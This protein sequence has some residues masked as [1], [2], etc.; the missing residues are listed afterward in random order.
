MQMNNPPIPAAI[1]KRL[2][3]VGEF[4]YNFNEMDE[5]ADPMGL[6]NHYAP[7]VLTRFNLNWHLPTDHL[8][9]NAYRDVLTIPAGQIPIYTVPQINNSFPAGNADNIDPLVPASLLPILIPAQDVGVDFR[10][11]DIVSERNS[12]KKIGRNAEEYIIGVTRRGKT[13]FL[14]R[15]DDRQRNQNDQQM[16]R[17]DPGHLFQQ[18]CTPGYNL[19]AEYKHL[20]AGRIGTFQT[21]ITAEID[22]VSPDDGSFL[23][24]KSPLYDTSN[25]HL[26]DKWLQMFLGRF[27]CFKSREQA[28]PL[29]FLGGVERLIVGRRSNDQ[30][31]Q[32]LSIEEKQATNMIDDEIETNILRHLNQVLLFLR[33][34]VEEDRSYLLSRHRRNGAPQDM[35]VFLYEVVDPDD[36]NRLQFVPPWMLNQLQVSNA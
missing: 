15:Y 18:M 1:L 2:S 8:A 11:Y 33:N 29:V 28:Y 5:E 22:V 10:L 12:L 16:D 25:L 30:P 3:R 23:E 21:L 6:V 34:N 24:L 36:I 9:K 7:R 14:R 35:G 17:N 32:L 31:P 27:N 26:D 19:Q 4:Q 13:L 20:I